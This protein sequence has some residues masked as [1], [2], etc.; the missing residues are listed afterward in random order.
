MTDPVPDPADE[1]LRILRNAVDH[2]EP[3]EVLL[4]REGAIAT[5]HNLAV[6][7]ARATCPTPGH[8]W[9]YVCAV[10]ADYLRIRYAPGVRYRC[11][12][13]GNYLTD[14]LEWRTL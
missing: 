8:S 3:C 1:A 14:G 11:A 10:H 9:H 7:A 12:E 5:C 4:E 13:H 2:L 6:A